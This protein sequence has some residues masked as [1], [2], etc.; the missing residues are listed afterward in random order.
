[1]KRR[2]RIKGKD[3]S[4]DDWRKREREYEREKEMDC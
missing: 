2:R 3:S 4:L 1:M